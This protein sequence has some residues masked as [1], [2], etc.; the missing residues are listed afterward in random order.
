M[1]SKKTI[2]T[3]IENVYYPLSEREYLIETILVLIW[4]IALVVVAIYLSVQYTAWWILLV[5]LA[6]SSN[7][8]AKRS[9]DLDYIPMEEKENE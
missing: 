4:N 2:T 3:D 7:K 6:S 9:R 5:L 1:K 8:I